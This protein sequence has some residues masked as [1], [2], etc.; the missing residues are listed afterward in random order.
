MAVKY[1][2]YYDSAND[3]SGIMGGGDPAEWVTQTFTPAVDHTVVFVRMVLA[4]ALPPGKFDLTAGTL[5]VGI[6]ATNAVSG[7]P[8]GPDLVS[9]EYACSNITAAY[10][11]H[12]IQFD[13]PL[14]LVA[15]T[16]YAI[17]ARA[18]GITPIPYEA[19]WNG[20]SGGT[21]A[22]GCLGWSS[23][24]GTTWTMDAAGVLY[25]EEWG[26][27]IIDATADG[28]IIADKVT[29]EL[30]RNIEMMH[31]GHFLIDKAGNAKYESRNARY[32]TGP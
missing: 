25:F 20:N 3:S 21:Y 31:A 26:A 2:N 10:K 32:V 6:R 19:S 8:E 24:S 22:G 17:V 27:L 28:T 29:L 13:I 11:W 18:T 30:I 1:E 16:K 5:T 7:K 12:V 23:D 4:G 14:S 9:G 15:A